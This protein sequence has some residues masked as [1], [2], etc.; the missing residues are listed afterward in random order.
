MDAPICKSKQQT[1]L[2]SIWEN[3]LNTCDEQQFYL[4]KMM[5]LIFSIIVKCWYLYSACLIFQVL[6][7]TYFKEH[8]S[9]VASKYSLCKIRNGKQ[10]SGI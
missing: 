5:M 2:K 3:L 6:K 4:F 10:C 7:N 8:L 9:E 1:D